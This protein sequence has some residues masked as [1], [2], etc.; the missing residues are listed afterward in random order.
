M[1]WTW[2][3]NP[4]NWGGDFF[5]SVHSW[6]GRRSRRMQRQVRLQRAVCNPLHR[7]TGSL[8]TPEDCT[9]LNIQFG[10]IPVPTSRQRSVYSKSA[11]VKCWKYFY[12]SLKANSLL[13]CWL[14]MHLQINIIS[15]FFFK[16]LCWPLEKTTSDK[17]KQKCK[18]L[19]LLSSSF[20]Q[21]L[22]AAMGLQRLAA[23]VLK[24]R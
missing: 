16:C 21:R 15:I 22:K 18:L 10:R 4:G 23:K 12:N 20:F 13:C 19:C 11:R 24:V 1:H 3:F 2:K 9:H 7:Q 14:L 17:E 5:L 8:M 6:V